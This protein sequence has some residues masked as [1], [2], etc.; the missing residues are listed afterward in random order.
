MLPVLARAPKMRRAAV[1]TAG[2]AAATTSIVAGEMPWAAA[3]AWRPAVAA[4]QRSHGKGG[5]AIEGRRARFGIPG[6]ATICRL[7]RE[8]AGARVLALRMEKGSGIGVGGM[9][10]ELMRAPSR[11]GGAEPVRA[12][13]GMGCAGHDGGIGGRGEGG[14]RRGRRRPAGHG[15]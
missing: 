8:V 4:S 11:M 5:S 15:E 6:A 1:T 7:G 14:E 3:R 12:H 2:S 9:G 10:H 13:A